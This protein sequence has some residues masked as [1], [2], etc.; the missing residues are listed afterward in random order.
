VRIGIG[1]K[2][3]FAANSTAI[4]KKSNAVDCPS[5]RPRRPQGVMQRFPKHLF[6]QVLTLPLACGRM[7]GSRAGMLKKRPSGRI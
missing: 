5:P 1:H 2:A 6:E 4:G 7:R 3:L